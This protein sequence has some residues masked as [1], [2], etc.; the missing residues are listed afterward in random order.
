MKGISALL[1]EAPTSLKT[2]L[3]SSP[4]FTSFRVTL[5]LIEIQHGR[6]T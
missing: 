2:S 1:V 3:I 6:I 5:H 4:K